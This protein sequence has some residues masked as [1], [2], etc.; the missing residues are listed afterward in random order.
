[1]IDFTVSFKIGKNEM[2]RPLSVLREEAVFVEDAR[3]G[4]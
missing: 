4:K 2:A 1:M 3:L